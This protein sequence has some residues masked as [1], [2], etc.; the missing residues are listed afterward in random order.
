MKL[1]NLKRLKCLRCGW[2]W[3]PRVKDVRICPNIKCHSMY[4]DRKRKEKVV[5]NKDK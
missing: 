5:G 1:K 4:W 2:R 3:L